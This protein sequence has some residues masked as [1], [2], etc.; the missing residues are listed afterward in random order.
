MKILA[1][2]PGLITALS[3]GAPPFSMTPGR[4]QHSVRLRP[5]PPRT[6]GMT[7]VPALRYPARGNATGPGYNKRVSP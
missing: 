7:A 4:G 1:T 3:M 5:A 6:D 2:V